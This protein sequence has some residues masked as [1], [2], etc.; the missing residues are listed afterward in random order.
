MHRDMLILVAAGNDGVDADED[1]RIDP[2]SIGPPATAK[3]CLS[4]GA[5]ENNRPHSSTPLPGIDAN[6]NQ[7]GSR[8]PLGQVHPT[9]PKLGPAGHVSDK[10]DGM[11]AFSSRGPTE[12]GRIKPDVVAPGTNILSVRSSA[13]GGS[14]PPLWGE[15]P[16]TDPIFKRY[17]WSGGTSMSTPLVA[18]AVALIRQ[19][20]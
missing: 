13:Y 16:T 7:L 4:V 1:G 14:I 11:A 19:H 5:C 17:C 2:G 18:G 6:W 3:N 12:E 10:P 15:L 9:W 8:D 20:L